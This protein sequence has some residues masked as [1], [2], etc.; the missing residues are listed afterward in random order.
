M[1]KKISKGKIAAGVGAAAAAAAAGYYF[2]GS[3]NAKK[4]RAAVVKEAN[5]D[6]KIIK[7]EAIRIKKT[8]LPRAKALGRKVLARGT[9]AV[10]KVVKKARAA[11][12][13]S[14]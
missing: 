2:Y 5:A 6:W 11:A 8:D 9:K 1:A 13:K 3:K 4:H 7:K 12:R 14:R 10:K